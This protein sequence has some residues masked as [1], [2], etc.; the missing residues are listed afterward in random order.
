MAADRAAPAR[1]ASAPAAAPV[2]VAIVTLDAHLADAFERARGTLERTVP[3]LAVSMH[4]AADFASDP[5]AALRACAA[6]AEAHVVVCTQLFQE[7]YAN[8]V[9]PAVQARR[10]T[11][12]AVV[13][14]L[15]TPELVKCT[16]LGRFDMSGGE[17]RSPFSPLALLKKLR[18]SR[19]E[20]RSSGERQM[21]ALRA[22]PALLRFIPGTA[23]DVRQYLLLMQYWLA[24]SE[25]N[26]VAMVQLLVDRYADGPRKGLRGTLRP[27]PPQ[28]YPEVGVWHPA[29]PG[30][31]L[32]EELAALE[33]ARPRRAEAGTVGVLVG[34]SYLLAGNV[35]HYAAVVTALEARGL[36]VIPAFA[37]ALDARPAVARYFTD[38]AGRGTIDALVNLT[39]FSLVGGPAYNDAAAA[40]AVL[41]QLDVP[42]L[43]LQTL[44]FQSI[45]EWRG[46]ARGLNPLQA[47]L[48][49]AIPELDGAIAP[50]VFGGK[51]RAAAGRAAASEPIPERVERVAAR[52]AR[53]VAL[54]RRDR[55]QRK[56]AVVLFN[57]PPNAGNTGSAAYLAVFPSLQRVLASMKEQGYTVELP[58]SADALREMV[59]QGNRERHGTPANVLAHIPVDDHVRRERHLAEIERT[60]GAAPGRQLANGQAIHVMGVRLGNVFVGVQP[61]FGWEGDPMRLLFEGGFAPT[62]AFSA[63]YR[64]VREDFGADAVLHFGT[65]GALEFM[66]G[67]QAGLDDRCW[68][69]R[70]IGDTP[71][72]YLYASNNS[73]EGTLAKRRGNAT[74]V[75]YLTPPIANAGLY[76]G[77]LELKGSLDRWRALAAGEAARDDTLRA[78]V[79][80]QAVAVELASAEPAWDAAEAEREVPRLRDRLLELEYALIPMGLHVVGEPMAAE[81]RAELLAEMARLGRPEAELP[82][83]AVLL[84][85]TEDDAVAEEAVRAAARGLVAAGEARGALRA[86]EGVLRA[87]GRRVADA[88][89]A[90]RYLALLQGVEEA[91]RTDAEIPG[92]LRALDGRYVPPAPGGDLLRTPAVLPTGRNLYGFDPYRVPSAAALLEGRQRA[93]HLLQRHLADGGAFPESVAVVLWGTDNMKSEGTPLAQVLALMGVAPRFD[94]V[95][96]LA[97][98]RLVPLAQLGRPRVD[99]VVTLSGIFRDLL[100]LQVRLLAE[101]ALL[102]AQADEDPAQN[103]VRKH[104]LATMAETGCDLPTAALRVF[105]NADGAYGSNVNLLIE[106][107]RWQ[108]EDEL[109]DLFV[110]RKG[111][112]Y[113]ADGRARSQPALMKRALGQAALSFQGLDSVD[114]G[115]TDIDQYVESLGGM[116]RVIAQQ[117]GGAAPA[118][119]VGD[120]TGARGKVRT[121]G[122]QVELESR[123]KLLNPRWYD[124]QLAHGYEGVRNIAGHMTATLGWSATGGQGAV[125]GWVYTEAAR[126]FV[127]DEAMREKLAGLNP[128]AALGV[129]QRL[130]EATDRGFWAPDDETLAALRDAAG[131]LEDRLEGIPAAR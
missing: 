15:C 38:G 82:S 47:T 52:V 99:V 63:F 112:A 21:G 107:G 92:V 124:A 72:V 71:N 105:S 16:R 58:A 109:A 1:R 103:F 50:T 33:R 60:W 127:L 44:E 57:F 89:G 37:S 91:L 88:G 30:R 122:E 17:A 78:L 101:A 98:A 75:S 28:V 68:P 51:G 113:G 12:D 84:A 86:A 70:L 32:T 100:P 123:T 64:W 102:C 81:A 85:G 31:G 69:D 121:L 27:P 77:L 125:P 59:T 9:L 26:L 49:V 36:R 56:V 95:G 23:Q 34:R 20:G 80:Q 118:V 73:S 67:K 8:A 130:L 74:L 115:A 83:L 54:R 2:R 43:T 22:L 116:T 18:G 46:D 45:D 111:F 90:E 24:G 114:L 128:D 35:A 94:A 3:G 131:A 96:R 7:E 117:R 104:A 108:S 119:Y 79:Q 65:H 5:E 40:Q 13:C 41:T 62:H 39:G 10:A 53:L 87:A 126:T 129:A 48:Q 120:Y 55:A 97:G 76:R 110:Q 29:L 11:A 93:D 42:Y 25:E 61:A 66:P 6:I 4:V 106:T 14:A 19:G